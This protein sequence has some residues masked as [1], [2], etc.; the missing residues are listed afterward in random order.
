MELYILRHGIAEDGHPGQPDSERALTPE[1][2]KKLR[3]ILRVARD[4]GVHPSLIMTSPLKRAVQTA[5]I[6][7]EVLE[8]KGELL[9]TKAL[10]PSSTPRTAWEEVRVHK[11]Q[12]QILLSGHD[13]LFS[14]LAAFLLG[15]PN[16]Q[17]DFKKGAIMRIDLDRFA[18]EPHGALKWMLVPKLA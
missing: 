5:Q 4:A 17:V 16:L 13:P 8:Y 3:A 12:T 14:T 18:A 11:D 6:A 10:I 1:G 15:Y 9:R 2:K 7:A